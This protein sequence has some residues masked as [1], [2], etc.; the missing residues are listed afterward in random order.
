MTKLIYSI[1][2][3][4]S[5]ILRIFDDFKYCLLCCKLRFIY[6]SVTKGMDGP[7]EK[8]K[9]FYYLTIHLNFVGDFHAKFE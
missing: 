1:S 7:N 6:F 4:F 9:G 5:Q 2:D 8:I 3:S